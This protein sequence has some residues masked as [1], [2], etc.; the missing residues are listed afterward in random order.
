MTRHLCFYS[1]AVLQ[2]DLQVVLRESAGYVLRTSEADAEELSIDIT[3]R[4]AFAQRK[5]QSINFCRGRG[6]IRTCG[7][8]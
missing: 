4:V 6:A 5:Q 2:N 3:F 1:N 8:G 7:N